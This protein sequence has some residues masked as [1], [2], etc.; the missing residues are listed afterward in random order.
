MF[1]KTRRQQRSSESS[2]IIGD[3]NFR[4]GSNAD[5]EFHVSSQRDQSLT[6]DLDTANVLYLSDIKD[7]NFIFES[8]NLKS[9]TAFNI[10]N[11]K[12]ILHSK[13]DISSLHLPTIRIEQ[14]LSSEWHLCSYHQ[15]RIQNSNMSTFHIQSKSRPVLENSS[16]LTFHSSTGTIPFDFSNPFITHQ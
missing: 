16:Q 15:L 4:A 11:S 7:C 2:C 6:F 8:S 3:S 9:V 12:I 1:A 13:R 5:T 14:S 10:Q